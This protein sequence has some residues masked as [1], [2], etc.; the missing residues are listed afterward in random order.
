MLPRLS[1]F[2]MAGK[3]KQ[4]LLE[5]A[6]W[7]TFKNFKFGH[8]QYRTWGMSALKRKKDNFYY[9]NAPK[10]MTVF[11]AKTSNCFHFLKCFI[12]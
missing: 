5:Q 8:G 1:F 10:K 9:K 3:C 7:Y 11:D 2:F 4:C 6:P 12:L